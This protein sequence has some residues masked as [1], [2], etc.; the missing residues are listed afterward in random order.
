[1]MMKVKIEGAKELLR[2]L[3]DKTCK[4]QMSKLRRIVYI[5]NFLAEKNKCIEIK[6]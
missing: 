5:Q 4:S 2:I 1:M 3:E 6:N